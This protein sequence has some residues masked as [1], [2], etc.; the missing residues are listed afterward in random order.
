MP[1]EDLSGLIEAEEFVR[2]VLSHFPHP[3]PPDAVIKSA[4]R[5]VARE[6]AALKAR[7]IQER[8]GT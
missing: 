1:S 4:A 3:M 7:S 6:M 2:R 8:E 5:R